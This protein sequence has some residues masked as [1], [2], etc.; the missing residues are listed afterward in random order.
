[1]AFYLVAD[2][3]EKLVQPAIEAAF[4]LPPAFAAVTAQIN[5]GDYL[6]CRRGSEGAAEILACV[7]RKTLN[8]YAASFR[9]GRHENRRKLYDLRAKT[10]CALYY[11][12]EG[13]AFPPPSRKFS[14]VP[15]SSIQ[16]SMTNLMV[17]D[18]IHV[19]LT[20]DPAGTAQRLRALVGAY[21]KAPPGPRP[22]RTGVPCHGRTGG[23]ARAAG[24][25]GDAAG[26][27]GAAAG[28]AGDAGGSAGDAG[29]SAG[30]AAGS[31]GD[32]GGGGVAADAAGVPLQLL[33]VI[34]KSD[35][36]VVAGMW[37]QLPGVSQKVGA[38]LATKVAIAAYCSGS[39]LLDAQTLRFPPSNR[40]LAKKGRESLAALKAGGA[41]MAEKVLAGVVG[42]SLPTAKRV[43]LAG[44]GGLEQVAAMGAGA[45]ASVSIGKQNRR[46]GGALA[47]KI[48]RLL[49]FISLSEEAGGGAL[50]PA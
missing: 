22:S 42:V 10:G 4:A 21:S 43:V 46:L 1:M 23:S 5:T 36:D 48:L 49:S 41:E 44:G 13:P 31:A 15:F 19:V 12:V 8:D 17:R 9:D 26:S 29:G 3:R 20:R 45:L 6:I 11:I 33:G 18:G 32:A 39:A 7:E 30:D 50:S 37:A 35:K 40:L 38:A 28:S 47:A 14:R 2:T 25:A 27:A 16:T 24:S 34:P